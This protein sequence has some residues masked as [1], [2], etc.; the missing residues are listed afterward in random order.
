MVSHELDRPITGVKPAG[1]SLLRLRGNRIDV[2]RAGLGGAALAAF[3]L[4]PI[5]GYLI[6]LHPQL[7]KLTGVLLVGTW[8]LLR[9]RLSPSPRMHGIYV[10][11]AALGAVVLISATLHLADPFTIDYTIRWIPFVVIAAIITDVASAVIGI[12]L[13]LGAAL[14]GATAAAFGALCSFL[15]LHEPRASG[16]LDDPNDLA[17]VLVAALPLIVAFSPRSTMARVCLIGSGVVIAAAT[18]TTLSRGGLIALAVALAW[19]IVRR[20]VSGKLVLSVLLGVSAVGFL[21]AMLAEPLVSKALS[22]K[23]YIAGENVDTRLMRWQAA[24]RMLADAPLFGVGPG[25]FREH[26]SSVSRL[27]E[28]A[29]PTAVAHNMYLEVGAEL[30]MLGL[31]V[32]V[33]M[34]VAAF[35]MSE[36]ALRTGAD[37]SL[38]VAVQASLLAI[39]VASAFLSEQYYF[40][41]WSMVAI[42]CAI[43]LRA[44]KG[45]QR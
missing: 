12:R 36:K 45:A 33:A 34:I 40:P 25:G 32:F 42:A 28:I 43:S 8:L 21:V 30:G 6:A 7:G 38:V 10:L 22:E 19:V 35:V 13:L 17:Y 26:Y 14:V 16:P 41:L 31:I 2:G 5:E 11:L 18:A 15:V 27:A 23:T 3:A 44:G 29:E 1:P 20:A 24:A 39:V 37:R 4:A 9:W